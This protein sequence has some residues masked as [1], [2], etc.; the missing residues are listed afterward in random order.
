[1]NIKIYAVHDSK[2]EAYLQPYFA[3]TA[4][5]AVRSFVDCVSDSNHP[6]GKNPED[7]TLFYLGEFDD[8]TGKLDTSSPTSVGNGLSMVKRY[9]EEGDV[10]LQKDIE[11][12]ELK[13][14]NARVRQVREV[15]S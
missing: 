11:D 9:A 8:V 3:A 12:P 10:H 6:F 4:G 1:M 7:Y 5:I 14:A 13:Y 2:A 15:N